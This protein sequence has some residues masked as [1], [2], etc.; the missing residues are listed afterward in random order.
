VG[1]WGQQRDE[2]ERGFVGVKKT[3]KQPES[4][5]SRR[6]PEPAEIEHVRKSRPKVAEVGHGGTTYYTTE[7]ETG[8]ACIEIRGRKKSYPLEQHLQSMRKEAELVSLYIPTVMSLGA[9]LVDE[10]I[11]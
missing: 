6:H 8:L 4:E 2:L 5:R 9:G 7:S 3:R 1:R 11:R 10:G